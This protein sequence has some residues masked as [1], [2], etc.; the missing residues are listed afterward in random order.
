M[1]GRC[2]ALYVTSGDLRGLVL[3]HE[4][5]LLRYGGDEGSI[6]IGMPLFGTRFGEGPCMCRCTHLSC[7]AVAHAR[8]LPLPAEKSM[9]DSPV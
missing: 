3:R 5:A 2:R 8:P 6:A 7:P 9:G 4:A 1:E